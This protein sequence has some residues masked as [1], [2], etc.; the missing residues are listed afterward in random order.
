M[1]P[2]RNFCALVPN[3]RGAS[4]AFACGYREVTCV[5]SVSESHN[6]ANVNKSRV[7][8]VAGLLEMRDR[9]PDL[10]V[11]PA[12]GTVFG[13]P[14]EGGQPLEKV[15]ELAGGLIGRGFADLEL[16]DTIGVGTP[17]QVGKLFGLLKKEY[18]H[19][20]LYAHLHDTRNNGVLNTWT[21]L[22]SGADVIHTSV[23]GLGGCPFAPGASGNTSTEDVVWILEKC[24][25]GTGIDFQKILAVARDMR[26]EIAGSYSGHHV[27]IEGGACPDLNDPA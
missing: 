16:A 14:F 6:R 23:G 17:V 5:I 11:I 10:K 13:C 8:S 20:T 1:F 25:I 24:G 12:L 27:F 22:M 4:D 9:L 21:A 7:E 3:L 19:V 18:P 15:M 2:D 26:A